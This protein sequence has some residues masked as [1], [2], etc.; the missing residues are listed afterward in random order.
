MAYNG[1][2]CLRLLTENPGDCRFDI[3]LMDCQ[4]PG[5]PLPLLVLF[6]RGLE[7][8]ACAVMDGFEATQRIRRM[9]IERG[10]KAVPIVALTAS[11]TKDYAQRCLDVG[12]SDVLFKPLRR[13]D[14]VTTLR[15]WTTCAPSIRHQD[16]K[17]TTSDP[18]SPSPPP[19][20]PTLPSTAA[21]ELRQRSQSRQAR[22]E[23]V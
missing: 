17:T 14:L 6:D 4:M 8:I 1:E 19:S 21:P 11:A 16:V 3:V 10:G 9:G 5:T 7:L 2:D 15:K 13:E 23:L 22:F 18:P 20:S 12:M